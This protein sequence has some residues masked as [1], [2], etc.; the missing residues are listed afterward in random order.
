[1]DRKCYVC[2][3]NITYFSGGLFGCE[4]C[5]CN[6]PHTSVTRLCYICDRKFSAACMAFDID[7]SLPAL[8]LCQR[9]HEHMY[10]ICWICQRP[11]YWEN[12][13][14]LVNVFYS[15]LKYNEP[16]RLVRPTHHICATTYTNNM[17]IF[18][19]CSR[20]LISLYL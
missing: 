11:G 1:M 5:K 15:L 16:D 18:N 6:Y 7:I 20:R 4:L 12:M 3:D 10:K 8:T 14:E 9:H 17:C 19:K 2:H 13:K